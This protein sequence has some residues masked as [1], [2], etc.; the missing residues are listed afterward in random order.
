MSK[1]GFTKRDNYTRC[2]NSAIYSLAMREHSRKEL[3]QKL[4]KKEYVEGVDIDKL[5]NELE[6]SNYLN[7][8]RFTESFIRYRVSKGQGS[9]K[10]SSELYVRGIQKSLIDVAL[11]NSDFNW[12][13]LGLQQLEKKFGKS[14]SVDYKEKTKRMRF[15]STRGFSAEVI[16]SIII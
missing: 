15:L 12:F 6:E 9:V 3:Y 16:H 2:K 11:V 14:K 5:L 8:Q 4:Q 13:D 10:I 7:E 1:L